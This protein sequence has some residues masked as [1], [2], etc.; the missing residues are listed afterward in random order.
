M[1][2]RNLLSTLD[3]ISNSTQ[4]GSKVLF[5]GSNEAKGVT[6]G[7]GFRFV[8]ASEEDAGSTDKGRV[9]DRYS[10]GWSASTDVRNQAHFN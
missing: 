1:K 9:P 8:S 10:S 5:N 4:F 3:R 7:D 6:V 2:S